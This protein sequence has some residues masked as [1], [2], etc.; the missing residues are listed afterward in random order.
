M[1]TH[2]DQFL[3]DPEDVPIEIN[4]LPEVFTVFRKKCEKFSKVRSTHPDAAIMAEN[5][6]LTKVAVMPSLEDLGLNTPTASSPL[7]LSF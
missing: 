5:N 3:F 1:H 2:Y 7:C 4:Q 6:H